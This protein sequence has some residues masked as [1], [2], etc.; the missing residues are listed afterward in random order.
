[1]KICSHWAHIRPSKSDTLQIDSAHPSHLLDLKEFIKSIFR[2]QSSNKKNIVPALWTKNNVSHFR[3]TNPF[4]SSTFLLWILQFQH[5][6]SPTPLK[7]WPITVYTI[8]SHCEQ[9]RPLYS[10]I[11]FV[12]MLKI[13]LYVSRDIGSPDIKYKIY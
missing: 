2:I 8:T 5:L 11:L 6:Y 7:P 3:Q 4:H 10:F 1:M 9:R 13:R 12:F